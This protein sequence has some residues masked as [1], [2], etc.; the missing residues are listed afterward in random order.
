[1]RVS[2]PITDDFNFALFGT[3]DQSTA[4]L[5]TIYDRNYSNEFLTPRVKK[6]EPA[7]DFFSVRCVEMYIGLVYNAFDKIIHNI[8]M[9]LDKGDDFA[10]FSIDIENTEWLI[11]QHLIS[12]HWYSDTINTIAA[13]KKVLVEQGSFL[14][15]DDLIRVTWIPLILA[16]ITT[17]LL[18]WYLTRVTAAF[19]YCLSSLCAIDFR[20]VME[21]HLL[22]GIFAGVFPQDDKAVFMVPPI[23]KAI[24]NFTREVIFQ[25]APDMTITAVNPVIETHWHIHAS[26][27]IDTNLSLVVGFDPS[28]TDPLGTH[29]NITVTLIHSQ[30]TI[31]VN[32]TGVPVIVDGEVQAY[33]LFFE[34]LGEIA[35][36]GELL[37][38]ETA[39]AE[40][41]IQ[42]IIPKSLRPKVLEQIRTLTYV[43]NWIAV[44]CV[45]IADYGTF[46]KKPNQTDA[47][48]LFRDGMDQLITD[49]PD[50][51]HV[52]S[53][54]ISEYILFSSAD[55]NPDVTGTAKLLFNAC[56]SIKTIAEGHGIQ[57]QF[58]AS[59][60]SEVVMGLMTTDNVTFDMFS[61]VARVSRIM[62]AKAAPNTLYVNKIG[63][64]TFPSAIGAAPVTVNFKN[65]SVS[66]VGFE[67]HV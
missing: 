37:R 21:N 11:S 33:V 28:V 27:C 34:D 52:K 36:Q 41:I 50:V 4:G 49:M 25:L 57:I 10:N 19:H 56:Q 13:P 53:V 63:F 32:S 35:E 1:M 8:T 29:R 18:L 12:H 20:A 66:Y 9:A 62:A 38:K 26:S 23:I 60:E 59:A 22:A 15:Y 17:V 39:E 30:T 65:G 64:P 43:A 42:S 5:L 55:D 45:Q 44:L 58:G 7:H 51:W 47:L 54:G 14:I 6:F 61:T 16:L 31:P 3:R 24:H 2:A 40:G 48:R 67:C 46:A